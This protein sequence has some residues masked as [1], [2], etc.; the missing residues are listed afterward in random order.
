MR[1]NKIA[2]CV[3]LLFFFSICL[4][5]Y[6]NVLHY[7]F[8]LD[9]N[10]IITENKHVKDFSITKIFTSDVFHVS[11]E[12]GYNNTDKYYRPL[13]ILSY[14]FEY[15][16]WKLNPFGYRLDNIILQS[17]NGFLLFLIIF[18]LFKDKILA[19]LSG[20]FFCI[21]PSQVC[22]VTFVAG[23]SNLLEM[24][25]MLSAMVAFVYCLTSRKNIYYY[26]SLLLFMG[27]L[28]TREGAMLLPLYILICAAFLKQD[29]KK[30]ILLLLPYL[31]IASLYLI[32]RNMFMS[33]DKLN[34]INS[35]YLSSA[36][37]F[38]LYLQSFFWQL[39]LPLKAKVSLIDNSFVFKTIFYLTSFFIFLYILV[40]AIVKK[41]PVILYGL[42][43]YFIGLLPVI[44]LDESIKYLGPILSEHYVYNASIGFSILLAYFILALRYHHPKASKILFI[45]ACSYFSLLTI[46]T[47]Y[48]YK[49]EL[50]FYEYASSVSKGDKIFLVGLGNAYFNNKQ[51]DL[52][53]KESKIMLQDDPDA[54]DA[55]FLLGNAFLGKKEFDKA[56]D[57]YQKALVLNPRSCLIYNNLGCAYEAQGKYV[58]S[59][60]AFNKALEIDQ[61]SSG[62]LVNM[63]RL[64][65]KNKIYD[66]KALVIYER[67][68]KVSPGNVNE[69]VA[70]SNYWAEAGFFKEAEMFLKEA[71]RLSPRDYEVMKKL[72]VIYTNMGNFDASLIYFKKSLEINPQ[73]K[74]L[75]RML[76]ECIS[77]KEKQVAGK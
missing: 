6:F 21:H 45:L 34:I 58:E 5:L 75:K 36:I 39:I 74:E 48:Y 71:L 55:Y 73:D 53:I 9:D 44:R 25:F 59:L 49:N 31:M 72:G 62:A 12:I 32:L 56:V 27:A 26:L 40:K 47:N 10:Y 38:V 24:F 43:M 18:L 37:S 63:S 42:A 65:I 4:V 60:E 41:K 7:P 19:L 1:K 77:L 35:A 3:L 57:E 15:P 16:I 54:W 68:L 64:L 13:Q 28:V 61:E 20:I 29:K 22:L 66:K 33:S 30:I 50:S 23:R 52:A 51:Y 70:V 69:L 2:N 67:M 11:S 14:A 17:I 46:S 8:I 76:D